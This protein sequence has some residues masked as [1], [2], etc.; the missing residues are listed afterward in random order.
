MG[1]VDGLLANAD[2]AESA[3]GKIVDAAES[4]WNTAAWSDIALFAGMEHDQLVSDAKDAVKISDA[5]IR[6]IRDLAE[7][8]VINHFTT[9]KVEVQMTNNNNINSDMDIDGI[10][11]QLEV[12]VEERLEA[13][14]EGVYA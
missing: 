7:R 10:I 5:D 6:K 11:N 9:A 4:V 14:A 8:E 3:M 13:V 1:F 12:K 2:S